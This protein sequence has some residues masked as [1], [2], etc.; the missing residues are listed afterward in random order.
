VALPANIF[1]ILAAACLVSGVTPRVAA[2]QHITV[3]GRFSPAQTLVGPNYSIGA[4]LGKQVGSN[5]FHSFGQFSL[6][7]A[8]APESATFTATGSTGPINNVIGRVTGGNQSSI[9]GAIVSAIS[10]ANLYLINPSGIVFGPNATVNVSGSFHASTADYLNM[11]D[12]AKFRATNPGGSTLSAAPPAAFG[13]LNANPAKISVN[14][15][16]LGPVPGTLGLVGGPVSITGPLPLG[17]TCTLCAPAGTIHVTSAAGTGEV[18][19]DPRNRPALTVTSF[20]PVSISGGSTLDVSN[21]SGLGSG[22]SVFIRAGALTIDASEINADNYGS[23]LGGLLLLRGDG[24]LALTDGAYVHSFAQASGGGAAVILRSATGGTLSADNSAVAVGSNAAGNS[25]KL[26][27]RGDQVSLS[28]GARLASTAQSTGN[29]GVIAIKANNLLIDSGSS[30]A[31]TTTGAGLTDTNGN[32]VPAGAGGAITITAQNLTFQN[33][34]Y[35]VAQSLGDGTGGAI[36]IIAGSLLADGGEALNLSTGIFSDTAGAGNGGSI[37]IVAGNLALHNGANVLA[38]ASGVPLCTGASPQ[39]SAAGGD[40]SVSVGGSLTIDSGASLGTL[41]FA[42][43]NAGNVSVGVSGPITIDMSVGLLSS[44]LNGIGSLAMGGGNAGTVR[45]TAQTLAITNNGVISSDTT[46]SGNG[47]DVFIE[48]SGA[49]SISSANGTPNS[50]TGI[51]AHPE[52]G[53]SGNAGNI[54]VTAGALSLASS[55][56]IESASSGSGNSGS[57]TIEVTGGISIDSANVQLTTGITSNTTV[58]GSPGNAGNVIISAGSLSLV[59]ANGVIIS[60]TLGTGSGGNISILVTGDLSIRDGSRISAGTFDPEGGNAGR[61]TVAA[62]DISIVNGA[63]ISTSTHGVAAAGEISVN[64]SGELVIDGAG[65]RTA[66]AIGSNAFARGNAGRVTVTAGRISISGGG[67]IQTAT[68]GSGDGGD[69]NVSALGNIL[70][71]G[72]GGGIV[73]TAEPGSVGRA[74]AI[75]LVGQQISISDGGLISSST[76]G[77]GKGGTVQVT[78]QGP[79]SLSDPGS[80]IIASASPTAS[81]SAGSVTVTAQQITVTKG[82][83]IASTTAGTGAGGSVTVTTPGALVLDG[84]GVANTQIAAS[85]IGPQSGPGGTVTVNANSLTVEGGAQIASKTAGPG[86]GGDIAVTVANGVTLSGVDTAGAASGITASAGSGSSGQAGQVV[87]T[88]GGAI[89]L[90]AGAKAASSTAGNGNG[91]TVQVTAQGPLTLSDPGTGITASAEPG[92]SGNAGSVA[93]AAPQITIASGAEIASTTAGTGAGGSVMVTTPGMLVL[94]GAGVVNTQI[95]ASATGPQSGPG[96]SVTVQADALSIA[97]G[98]QIASST[99]GP[100][101]GGD[102]NIAV[103]SDIVL[104]DAG[105]QITARSTGSGDAGSITVSAARLLMNNGAAISTE[106]A[107]STANGGN[108]TLHLRD[109]L[110]LTS[111]EISTSVKGETGNGGNIAIDPQLVILDHS[112]IIAQAVEG[113]GGNITIT[114]GQFIPSSDSIVS[115]SSELGISGTIVI[116]GPWVDVNGALVVLS[117]QLRSRT[118]V[119]RE[120]CAARAGQPISSLVEA[121]RGGLPQDPEATL[122]AL[123]IAGRDLDP[124]PHPGTDTVELSGT[125]IHATARLTMRC[126]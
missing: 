66:T 111:S 30:V 46:A 61:I 44:I 102:V 14:G 10:G 88:A 126:S 13:F 82:A 67:E 45:V 12:G 5:L 70:I 40:L 60:D 25:G 59:G 79:L 39:G 76:A 94:D 55:G 23:G 36:G 120:A 47:G 57:V 69:I 96:G 125:A 19:V 68:L 113:H 116:N 28:N 106:A 84:A 54:F 6:A 20:G 124:N 77:P 99:A 78:A 53:S 4:S 105:P 32:P 103:A 118:E 81:G 33:G 92:S 63:F 58:A 119:L 108:I 35:V 56:L 15:S 41:A 91:G 86:A 8:P 115:A 71:N 21:P 64:A 87:L 65:G 37:T 11:S 107:A 73:A 80:G 1:P 121:G 26:V 43:G 49:L 52:P 112:S 85:A 109:L 42:D 7:N 72:S 31:S 90:S 93:A 100:G 16:T 34:A 51:L 97:G 104:P 83:Q 22:G 62:G 89:A 101:K 114:A 123:Y 50:L 48:V 38:C 75:S 117:T 98:A 3:D 74:G 24:Q 122:P 27:L 17:A 9:N 29:G 110:Y 18:P 95:A 2:A